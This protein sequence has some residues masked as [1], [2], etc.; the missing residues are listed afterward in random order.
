MERSQRRLDSDPQL[1]QAFQ[2]VIRYGRCPD[3]LSFSRLRALGMAV[4]ESYRRVQPRCR[5]YSE[6]FKE[7]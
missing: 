5:L 4:G 6:F 7:D 2:E 1:Q 3:S